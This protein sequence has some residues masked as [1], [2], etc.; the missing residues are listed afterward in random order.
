M[1]EKKINCTVCGKEPSGFSPVGPNDETRFCSFEC[2]S[3]Y[4]SE[5]KLTSF[6]LKN[7]ETVYQKDS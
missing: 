6:I 3:K 1:T 7:G 5:N 2:Q 4:C